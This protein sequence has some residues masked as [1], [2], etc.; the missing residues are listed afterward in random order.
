[1]AK[2]EDMSL[3]TCADDNL[4]KLVDSNGMEVFAKYFRRLLVGN[5]PQIFPG[6]SRNVENTGNYP[7]LVQEIEKASQDPEKAKKIAETI[8]TSEGDIFRDFDLSTFLNHFKLDPVA[9]T[10][11]ASAFTQASKLGLRVKGVHP[12][13]FHFAP[14]R[15]RASHLADDISCSRYDLGQYISVPNT[16][17]R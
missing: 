11:M 14:N 8:D 3:E 9:K 12:S 16:S 1:L 2:R 17:I 13:I 10:V 15:L 6:I 7:L 4:M 5:S